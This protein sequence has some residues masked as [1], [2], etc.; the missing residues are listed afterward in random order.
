M[1][2]AQKLLK[3]VA[4]LTAA[5]LLLSTVGLATT[6]VAPASVAIGATG[7]NT[8]SVTSSDA[9]VITYTVGSPAYSGGDPA[10]LTVSPSGSTTTAATASLFFQARNAA[11]LAAAVHTATVVL[12]P[13]TP[14]GLAAVQITVTYDTSGGGGTGTGTTLVGS[15]T[16]VSLNSTTFS[17]TVNITN[18]SSGTVVITAATS[19]ATGSTNWLTAV[20]SGFTITPGGTAILTISGASAGLAAGNYQG[21]A[22]VT[23]SD[24]SPALSITVNFTVGTAVGNGTWVTL[25]SSVT[26]NFTTNVGTYPFQT[27]SVTTTSGQASYSINT[28]SQSSY[29]WLLV[30]A[31]GGLA[32]YNQTAI[33]V[34]SPFTLSVGSQANGL[35]Q[36]TYTDQ[37]ILTDPFGIQQAT[38]T[39]TLNVNGG[40][41]SGLTVTPSSVSLSSAVNGAQQSQVINVNSSAGG[42]LTV[43]GCAFVNW[44]TCALPSNATVSP[45]VP[46]AFTIYA[47][48]SGLA[49]NTYSSTMTIQVGS[50]S[51]TLNVSLVVGGGGTGNTLVA[52]AALTFYYEL[53]TNTSFVPQQKLVIA[54][55]PGAWSSTVAY[56]TSGAWLSVSPAS[57]TA[58][59]DPSVAAGTPTVS[60]DPTGLAVG[61]YGGSVTINTKGGSQV[62]QAVLN[63]VST[64]IILPSPA[65]M[66]FTA[67]S[68]Q[69]KPSPQGLFWGNSD[70]ALTG[71]AISAAA[72]NTWIKLSNVGDGTATVNV[73]HTGL[74]VGVNTGSITLTQP[75]AGNTPVTVPVILVVSGNGTAGALTFSPSSIA[76]SAVAGS[77]TPGSAT[78]AVSATAA[79]P[80]AAT[81]AYTTGSN[82]LTVSPLSGTTPANL[83]VSAS[84]AGLTAG[85]YNATIN[86]TA[87]GV[88]QTVNVTLTVTTSGG[89][90][91]ISVAPTLL[92]FSASLGSSPAT[93]SL[94]VTSASGTAGI[95]FTVTPITTGGGSWL[96]T[97]VG[98]GTTPLNPLTVTVNSS[99]LVAGTYTGSILITPT[100]GTAI[101]IPVTL[102]VTAAVAISATPTQMSFT[103]RMGDVAPA[104]QPVTVSGTGSAFSATPTSTG[105]WLVASPGTGTA[106]ATV[107]VSINTSGL[108][109]VG[110]FNGTIV[111]AGASGATGSSTITVTLTVTSPLPT[112][113][114]VTNG[115]SYATTS[116]SPGEIITLFASDPTHPIGPA[117]PAFLALDA[118]G[119]VA[120]TIGGVQVTVAGYNCPMIY[121]SATQVSAVV[122]YEV[123][124]LSA[125]TVLVKFLG[126]GSN[127]ILMN[128][129]TTL[130]GLFTFNASGTGEGAILNSD[131]SVNSSSN[132]AARGDVVVLYLTGEGDTSP[133]GVTGKVTT[134]DLTPGHPLTPGPL[135]TPSVTIGGQPANWT[136][137]GEAP[138]FV[139][140]V[141]QLNVVV[142]TNISAGNQP[143]VVTIGG[144]SSQTPNAGQTGV[145]VAL[146]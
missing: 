59:P 55:T 102:T 47:N 6:L 48:P 108:T 113:T 35:A 80:F 107:N 144:N 93:Q 43:N 73:D 9:T 97:S 72:N 121:A 123:K 132:P 127:G 86:F 95:P 90:G 100:G 34:G 103:Y 44:L 82:W 57:G 77:A 139:S 138:G 94:N 10:W 31:N 65:V 98:F 41:A 117:T 25:P 109:T 124:F 45:N 126:Q 23:P 114:R 89:G 39:V 30:A 18:T 53:G 26:W 135:L 134:V 131:S 38:I 62:L 49:A 56:P 16:S 67:Q 58:L 50:Q 63:V 12:A 2:A 42:T 125:A 116:V 119:N 54:G 120:T 76:L 68:G 142:P 115:A 24:G 129:T 52:P 13:T 143:V 66:I 3:N 15:K 84:G 136:F 64:T 51:G 20:L 37:A 145:T 112:V 111:V 122:P 29:H 14:T 140:G 92:A 22:T 69:P 79:T 78:L 96:S 85:T 81:V 74:P 28:T 101:N 87:N 21:T 106:P 40:G 88:V 8:A 11:G 70:P 61:S 141:M 1:D 71:V 146:K 83:T 27:V 133:A 105:N 130:P 104:S 75:G 17:D 36:G 4:I 5:V 137:A 33:P 46:I 19:V 118:N 99:G 32:A 60:A 110:T 7:S 128:V 91:N